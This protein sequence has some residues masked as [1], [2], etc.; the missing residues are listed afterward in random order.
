MWKKKEE[1]RPP[2][3]QQNQPPLPNSPVYTPPRAP[4]PPPA[5][6][7]AAH[8]PV[9]VTPVAHTPVPHVPAAPPELPR[10]AARPPQAVLRPQETSASVITKGIVISGEILG[11]EDLQI[12]GEVKGTVLVPDARVVV[13]T[14][15][16]ASGSIEAR[17]I[18]MRGKLKGNLRASERVLVG[19]TSF[20]QGDSISPRLIIEE[21]AVV[22]GKF[23]VAQPNLKKP[24]G[25]NGKPVEPV[26][27]EHLALRVSESKN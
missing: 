6:P 14:E 15:G 11:G 18:V 1:P 17:E 4:M 8:Q 20:W 24:A 7:V 16:K 26:A 19:Q 23:E 21:G 2:V 10:E 25:K 9:P 12:D 3:P 27:E 22:R 5:N 13:T